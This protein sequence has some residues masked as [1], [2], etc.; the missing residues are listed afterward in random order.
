MLEDAAHGQIHAWEA[1][2]KILRLR[3]KQKASGLVELLDSK[4]YTKDMEGHSQQ[5]RAALLRCF[6]K[7]TRVWDIAQTIIQQH[8]ERA[9]LVVEAI[10]KEVGRGELFRAFHYNRVL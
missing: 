3:L 2:Y 8:G 4:L 1:W 9:D 6:A 10:E 7:G 5:L